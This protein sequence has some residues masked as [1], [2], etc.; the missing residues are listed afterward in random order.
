MNRPS[1]SELYK[2]LDEAR[3]ALNCKP[4]VFA[5]PAKTVGE[6]GDLDINDSAEVWTLIKG[7][8][9]E[10]KPDDYAGG[11]PPQKSYEKIIE[12]RELFAFS[13]LSKM[14]GKK[15]YI[16]FALK[17]HRYYYVSLHTCRFGEK[18]KEV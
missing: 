7:L 6:L 8:L 1:D 14:L 3:K 11:R 9:E 16:K 17:D 12:G 2:K 13:W 5:N 10:I 18:E 15:M 4:G